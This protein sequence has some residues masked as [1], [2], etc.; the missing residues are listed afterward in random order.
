MGERIVV[1]KDGIVHQVADPIT[2]YDQPANRFVAGF[3][4]TPP[5][6]FLEGRL[7]GADNALFFEGPATVKVPVPQAHLKALAAYRDKPITLGIRPE[8]IGSAMAE[9]RENPPR[10][11]ASVEV[12]EPM[13]AE[14]YVYMRAGDGI[15][16]SRVD[17]HRKFTVGA[18]AE[19]AVLMD[20]AHFFDPQT[21]LTIV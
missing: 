12:V 10:I 9:S 17:A 11:K 3:I 4:G 20:K 6:N 18:T 15:F 16:I 13:G 1:M 19:P 7:T 8:D 21:E 2:L 14:S 5:M